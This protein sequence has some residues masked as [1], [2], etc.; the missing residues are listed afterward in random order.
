MEAEYISVK[1][2]R[3]LKEKEQEKLRQ[4]ARKK[5]ET[6]KQRKDYSRRQDLFARQTVMRSFTRIPKNSIESLD[7]I[8]EIIEYNQH[9]DSINRLIPRSICG[10]YFPTCT[11][12]TGAGVSAYNFYALV[13]FE[14][15]DFFISGVLSALFVFVSGVFHQDF[16]RYIDK[17]LLSRLIDESHLQ[18][19]YQATD[20]LQNTGV[21]ITEYISRQEENRY[22]HSEIPSIT[23][24]FDKVLDTVERNEISCTK[25]QN[26][27]QQNLPE[28]YENITIS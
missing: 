22:H 27:L 10:G 3:R 2:Y 21:R 17:H 19:M 14:D 4:D 20:A 18:T 23:A 15:P 26:S 12:L 13:K 5:K 6:R 11:M 7:D 16:V 25:L 1:E 24:Y 28:H 9:A 8:A